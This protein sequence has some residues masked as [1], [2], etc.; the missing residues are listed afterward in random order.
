MRDSYQG[1]FWRKEVAAVDYS[2]E[3]EKVYQKIEKKGIAVLATACNPADSSISARP[4]S[5][6][7]IG[8][9]IAFQTSTKLLKY[10][11]IST[12]P[13]AALSIDNIS[14]TGNATILGHPLEEEEFIEKF[15]VRHKSSFENY[16]SMQSNRVIEIEP[17]HIKIWE[18][19]DGEPYTATLDTKRKEIRKEH[20][21]HGK[22]D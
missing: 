3:L 22:E 15:R 5:V 12:N 18:Y 13:S 11:Q 21:Q 4:V 14:I 6:V 10:Q 9:K 19:I 8:D 17:L 2:A 20:Y 7:V 1:F 16:S